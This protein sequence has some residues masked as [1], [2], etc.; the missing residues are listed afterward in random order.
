MIRMFD[1][2]RRL[3]LLVI[4]LV[5]VSLTII[6]VD[7]RSHGHGPLDKIG[8]V[9]MTIIG[10]V[11]RGLVTILHPIGSFFSGIGRAPGLEN[12]IAKYKAELATLTAQRQ[13]VQDMARENERLRALLGLSERFNLNTMPAQVIGVSPS[14]FERSIIIDRGSS[15]GVKRDMPIIA[16][17]G[18]VGRVT[19]VGSTT[20]EVLLLVSRG[21]G[22]AGR[23]ARTGETGVVNGEGSNTARFELLDPNAKVAVGDR[24]VTSGYDNGLY[25]PGIPIGLVTRAPKAQGAAL[26]RIVDVQP[27][28][29]FSSLDYVLLVTGQRAQPKAS[30]S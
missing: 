27:F 22:V 18:L 15:Q 30:P 28:V 25:P 19:N 3:R 20:A 14:N 9:A 17:D 24:I 11:Q 23:V 26:E 13:Q 16:G 5:I 10:P 12:E 21:S 6:T 4:S 8:H 7:F 1:R 29:D 2:T